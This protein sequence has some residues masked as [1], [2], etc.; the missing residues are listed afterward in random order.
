MRQIRLIF[1][2]LIG[3]TLIGCGNSEEKAIELGF[4]SAAQMEILQK[5]GYKTYSQFL[6]KYPF[7]TNSNSLIFAGGELKKPGSLFGAMPDK[8]RSYYVSPNKVVYVGAFNEKDHPIFQITYMCNTSKGNGMIDGVGCAST[9]DQLAAKL[10]GVKKVCSDNPD[11]P[12]VYVYKNAFWMFDHTSD[13]MTS[14]GLTLDPKYFSEE[15]G[16]YSEDNCMK[17]SAE[18]SRLKAEKIKQEKDLERQHSAC[19]PL[20]KSNR[21]YTLDIFSLYSGKLTSTEVGINAKNKMVCFFGVATTKGEMGSYTLIQ[22]EEGLVSC[23]QKTDSDRLQGVALKRK[24]YKVMGNFTE[25]Y[26]NEVVL[27]NCKFEDL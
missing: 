21:A 22:F 16:E 11:Y 2:A 4:A 27:E 20:I 14:L 18:I 8:D 19:R 1:M 15:G 5:E 23:K 7:Q 10:R 25:V 9:G 3:A 12:F 17:V 13:L 24:G 26:G 6:E